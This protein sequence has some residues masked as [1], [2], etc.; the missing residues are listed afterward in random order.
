[1]LVCF[2]SV[3]GVSYRC[4]HVF[5]MCLLLLCYVL[6]QVRCLNR[7]VRVFL[8][9][10]GV[11]FEVFRGVSFRCVRVFS[12]CWSVCL[13]YLSRSC[14]IDVFV[15]F[16]M[17]WC[18]FD[19]LVACLLDVMCVF[20]VFVVCLLDVMCVFDVFVVCLLD[21]LVYFRC[22]RGLSFRCVGVFSM[23]SWPVF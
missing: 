9:C 16:Q 23:F 8:E 1:M 3:R 13:W 4:V 20:D 11:F 14:L 6:S 19:V 22:F 7:R 2:R 17:C 12:M 10:V 15:S 18:V 21:V 5:S